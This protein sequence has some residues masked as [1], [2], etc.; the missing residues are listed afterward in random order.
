M[1][2]SLLLFTLASSFSSFLLLFLVF[3]FI[4]EALRFL[5]S[6]KLLL[7]QPLQPF[8]LNSILRCL[9]ITFNLPLH[10]LDLTLVVLHRGLFHLHLSLHDL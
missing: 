1:I 7:P 4:V 2:L 9:L 10:V 5:D 6:L 3:F 8:H